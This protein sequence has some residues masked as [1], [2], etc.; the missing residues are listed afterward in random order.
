MDLKERVATNTAWS[1][2]HPKALEDLKSESLKKGIW[3][4]EGGYLDKEPPAPETSV[5]VRE[6][7]R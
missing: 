6:A 2:H 5:N 1:W 4:E 7:F 3:I